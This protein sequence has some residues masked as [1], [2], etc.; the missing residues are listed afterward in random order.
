MLA[1]IAGALVVGAGAIAADTTDSAVNPYQGVVERNVFALKPP[2]PPPDPESLKPPAPEFQLTGI[3]T[4]FGNKRALLKSIPKAG[5]AG[6]PAEK[7]RSYM[8]TE[9]QRE[10][11]LQVDRIDEVARTVT[12]TYA[13]TVSTLDFTNNAAKMM[14]VAPPPMPAMPGARGAAPPAAAGIHPPT[15]AHPGLRQ[16]AGPASDKRPMRTGA[17]MGMAP[18]AMGMG[19]PPVQTSLAAQ[20]P[21]ALTRDQ[22]EVVMEAMREQNPSMPPLPPTSL[23]PLIEAANQEAADKA[24]Y[25]NPGAPATGFAPGPPR[26]SGPPPMPPMPGPPRPF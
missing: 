10:D 19:V 3:T 8:L 18:P 4:I 13:G 24:A 23:T 17:G 26:M 15:P 11:D 16:P 7:E 9:G 20:E 12:V 21:P 6:Q 5:K 1:G 22:Q 25:A 14:A 2:P